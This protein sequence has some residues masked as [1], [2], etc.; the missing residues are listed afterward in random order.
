MVTLLP[1]FVKIA[2]PAPYSKS[3]HWARETLSLLSC[4]FH[5]SGQKMLTLFLKLSSTISYPPGFSLF[6]SP[7][8]PFHPFSLHICLSDP[9]TLLSTLSKYPFIY[10]FEN[11]EREERRWDVLKALCNLPVSENPLLLWRKVLNALKRVPSE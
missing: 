9:D 3:P 6:F 10:L 5:I 7:P 8:P 1:V 2:N 11:K 4:L